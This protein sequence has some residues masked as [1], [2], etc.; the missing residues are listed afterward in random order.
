MR[1]TQFLRAGQV[2]WVDDQV[3]P[4][5]GTRT[6][7]LMARRFGRGTLAGVLAMTVVSA[8]GRPEQAATAGAPPPG[9]AQPA[10][11][12]I[13]DMRGNRVQV[14][15][16]PARVALLGGPSGQV[17]FVLGVQDSLC[18]VTNT[19]R[20]SG[21]VQEMDPRIK[22]LPGPRTTNGS[23]NVEE[24]IASEPDLVVA[25]DV[26][27][28]IV[29]RKS[30]IPVALFSDSMDQGYESAIREIRFYGD[31][32]NA[33]PRA[34]RYVRY[35]EDTV[36]LLKAR[37]SDIP[38]ASRPFVYNG[39]DPSH[40]VTF[41]GD[42][43]M[44]ERIQL[45]G[46]RNAAATVRT[47]GKREGLHSGLGEVSLEDVV[48]WD[49]DIL[50]INSGKPDELPKQP[51]WKGVK[52]VQRGRVYIEPAGIF[53]FNRP[54]MES[55]V[56]YPLWLATIAHPDRFHDIDMK[57][58]VERFY[59]EVFEFHLSPAQVERILSGQYE[60][61]IMRGANPGAPAK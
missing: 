21:L 41:G 27:G 43:F 35:L 15:E 4:F 25:G 29:R 47:I 39:Y 17:A 33:G 36:K 58:E 49:P 56:L 23:V 53:I 54:T 45:A 28:E 12:T 48:K 42:T 19:L 59:R 16:H 32:F 22:T 57:A 26:D 1:N 40:L 6:P 20:L 55:A 37:T 51:A 18:A 11:R 44:D 9:A 7:Q 38:D 13:T 31:V 5:P 8:C 14:P 61:Q 24:L 52:A 10:V 2:A 3:C 46:C 30:N 60:Q 50:V 34:E